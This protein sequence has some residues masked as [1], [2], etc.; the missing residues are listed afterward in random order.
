[1]ATYEAVEDAMKA[2]DIGVEETVRDNP[3]LANE[4]DTIYWD[5]CQSTMY[6]CDEEIAKELARRTGVTWI[7]DRR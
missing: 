3:K 2:V 1:M 4:E 5:I 7:G 6:E